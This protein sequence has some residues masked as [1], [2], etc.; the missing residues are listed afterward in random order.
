MGLPMTIQIQNQNQNHAHSKN[1]QPGHEGVLDKPSVKSSA[2]N[3]VK[4]EKVSLLSPTPLSDKC[5]SEPQKVLTAR[6]EV[7]DESSIVGLPK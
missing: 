5:S 4:G 1:T 7:C 3:P 6:N 2:R